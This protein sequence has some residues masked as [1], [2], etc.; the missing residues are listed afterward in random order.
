MPI[1]LGSLIICR[2]CK[3][4]L[5]EGNWNGNG[6]L[7]KTCKELRRKHNRKIQ[8]R[9]KAKRRRYRHGVI[10]EQSKKNFKQYYKMRQRNLKI[11]TLAHYSK[12]IEC[13]YCGEN[14]ID[15]LSLDHVNGDGA[16]W[17][18]SHTS[19]TYQWFI[20]NNFPT[21][22]PIQV[23][24]MNCQVKKRYINGEHRRK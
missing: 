22:P 18:R 4:E 12:L 1:T 23:L 6:N 15:V 13:R 7:C 24:C 10:T 3:V 16:E 9:K 21:D 8:E 11:V 5:S 2:G 17:R 20:N 14:D 19:H